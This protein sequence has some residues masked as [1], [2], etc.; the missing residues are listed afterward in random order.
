MDM[1]WHHF[2]ISGVE[3]YLFIPP[4]VMFVV[5]SLTSMAGVS[6]AFI[7]LPFQMSI[8]GY[9]TPGVTATNFVYNIVAIPFGVFQH[10]RQKRLAWPLFFT[11]MSGTLP[12]LF[13]GYYIRVTYLPNPKQFKFFAGLVLAFLAVRTIQSIITDLKKNSSTN[14]K[15]EIKTAVFSGGKFG[16]LRTKIYCGDQAYSFPTLLLFLVSMFVGVVGGSYGIGGGAILAP[17]CISVLNLPIALVSGAAL[18]ST[19]MSS[20]IAALFYAFLPTAKTSLNTSPDWALG[21]LF[22]LGGMLGI[23]MGTF[24]QKCFS[25][26]WIKIILTSSIIII[27]TRYIITS[28]FAF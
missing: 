27:A 23:Y 17:F 22:G 26:I 24:L 9:T 21:S 19:W 6:G 3:T 7:L 13:F 11:L 20:V 1:L 5:S 4:L 15:K 10:I 12:G 16:L 18:F 14:Q 25:S 28:L 8:L 2:T